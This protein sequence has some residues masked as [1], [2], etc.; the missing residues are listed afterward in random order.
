[1]EEVYQLGRKARAEG[2]QGAAGGSAKKKTA[3][4]VD[5]RNAMFLAIQARKKD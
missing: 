1:V 2:S 4:L 3:D 5:A